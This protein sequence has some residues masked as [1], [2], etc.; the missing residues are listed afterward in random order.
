MGS[1]GTGLL[2]ND[3]V[4]DIKYDYGTLLAY[5]VDKASAF[6]KI[7]ERYYEECVSSDEED[8]FWIAVSYVNHRYGLGNDDIIGDVLRVLGDEKYPEV[9]KESGKKQY[10]KRK[11]V[12]SKFRD[13][14]Q[15][16][17]RPLKKVPKPPMNM[18]YKTDLKAGDVIAYRIGST[19][20]RERAERDNE[21]SGRYG[22]DMRLYSEWVLL[23]V[24]EI[25]RRPVS[26]IM[27]EL[28]YHSFALA[29]LYDGVYDEMPEKI[30]EEAKIIKTYARHYDNVF[31]E[32][33][34]VHIDEHGGSETDFPPEMRVI[35]NA[36]VSCVAKNGFSADHRELDELITFSLDV[37]KSLRESGSKCGYTIKRD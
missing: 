33:D 21:I 26:V 3:C 17:R 15:N 5:G 6:A 10:E 14:L 2:Q 19:V 25:H 16:E 32:R 36:P 37:V 23:H 29:V 12:I 11:Q 28:D 20:T 31:F 13:E 35:A 8:A 4:S 18:R 9:W 27:P 22:K 34:G 1:W 30:P 7:K 24:A